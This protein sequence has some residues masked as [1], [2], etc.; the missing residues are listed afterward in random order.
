M[1]TAIAVNIF[2]VYAMSIVLNAGCVE[3]RVQACE[4]A[5]PHHYYECVMSWRVVLACYSCIVFY[6]TVCS[7]LVINTFL[8]LCSPFRHA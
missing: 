1:V 2:A 7:S 6:V 3:E 8:L 5:A 4:A